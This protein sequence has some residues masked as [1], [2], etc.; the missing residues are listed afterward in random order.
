MR[1]KAGNSQSGDSGALELVAGDNLTASL[2]ESAA[3]E[4]EVTLAVDPVFT[5]I[6][7]DA[8]TIADVS[9]LSGAGAPV[10]YTDGDPAATGEGTAGIGSLYVD[11]TAGELYIN[12]GTQAEPA[13]TLVGDQTSA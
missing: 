1:I 4:V 2:V 11:T 10:D 9:L 8:A 3:G 13:W 12:T 5:E 7:A 6:T